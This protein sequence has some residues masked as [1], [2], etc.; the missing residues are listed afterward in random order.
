MKR[1]PSRLADGHYDLLVVGGGIHGACAAWDAALRGLSVALV[2][3]GDFGAATSSNSLKIIHGGLRYLQSADLPR[4]RE[5][6]RERATLLRIA[7]HLIRPLPFLIPTYGH[8]TDG[9]V[10][11][12]IALRLTDLIGFDRNRGLKEGRRVPGGRVLTRD[13]CLAEF[14]G[15]E[16]RGLTGGALW[17]DAQAVDTERLNLAFL[18]SASERGA[19]LANYVRSTE[20]LRDGDAVRGASLVDELT[21]VRFD[22]SARL[23]LNAAGPWYGDV[24]GAACTPD[25]PAAL[26]I[27]LVTTQIKKSLAVGVRSKVG[28][29]GD[30]VIGGHRYLFL[31]PW[32]GSTL[33]GTSYRVYRGRVDGCRVRREDLRA[34]LD[35]CNE[36]CPDLGLKPED[37]RFYH[38]G[39][40]PLRGGRERGRAD[41]LAS[42]ARIVDHEAEDGIR[43]L[44]SM[45]GVKYTTAR[46][47]AEDAVDLV[48]AK[49]GGSD[50]PCRTAEV[51]IYGGDSGPSPVPSVPRPARDRLERGH[52]SRFGDVAASLEGTPGWCEPVARKSVLLLGE[53]LHAV[54]QEMAV[55][56]GDVVFRRTGIG[57]EACPSYEQLAA[58]ADVM[59]EELGWSDRTREAEIDRVREAYAPLPLN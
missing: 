2:D 59:G 3:R 7:P 23:V 32:R 46:Q 29:G 57:A 51:P 21:G 37:V 53:V 20:L 50:T 28:P 49:L 11:L 1:D 10:A 38:H 40:L 55:K 15:V 27:N 43:G 12:A 42:D 8:G 34:L 48:V 17:Y 58:V 47:A 44:I 25:Q 35:E 16:R 31:T 19:E 39:L 30:P 54:R 13:E 56:L 33:L 22:L 9:K 36:A 18:L 26:A 24:A 41:A 52:G 45:V 14:P 4:M 6:I 5:S